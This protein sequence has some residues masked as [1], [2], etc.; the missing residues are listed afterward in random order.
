MRDRT[1]C[2][3][4]EERDRNDHGTESAPY[5]IL[6]KLRSN[7][8]GLSLIPLSVW[9]SGDERLSV[10]ART[11]TE[12]LKHDACYKTHR[13]T[14]SLILLSPCPGSDKSNLRYNQCGQD[15]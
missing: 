10:R 6:G 11:V 5:E 15:S 9:L 8:P 13:L 7:K 3:S 1:L 12:L 2:F 4:T 14:S